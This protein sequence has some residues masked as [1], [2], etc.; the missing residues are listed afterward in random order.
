MSVEN[1]KAQENKKDAKKDKKKV[2]EEL[3]KIP[4]FFY[5]N[6]PSPYFFLKI[7]LTHLVRRR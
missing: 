2:E 3:V 5:K 6:L 1:K 4:F 7:Q